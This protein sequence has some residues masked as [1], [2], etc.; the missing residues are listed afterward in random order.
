MPHLGTSGLCIRQKQKHKAQMSA[1]LFSRKQRIK[2]RTNVRNKDGMAALPITVWLPLTQR[3]KGHVHL[4]SSL[5][6]YAEI[7]TP[8]KFVHR[9]VQIYVD[10]SVFLFRLY[11]GRLG[12]VQ[13][14]LTGCGAEKHF[15]ASQGRETSFSFTCCHWQCSYNFQEP[16]NVRKYL[17]ITLDQ[18]L[19]RTAGQLWLVTVGELDWPHMEIR[20]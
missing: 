15:Q 19:W 2:I 7:V 9:Q 16:E 14:V 4:G 1:K 10:F 13:T 18:G 5:Q 11:E 12:S 6:Y 8:C 3:T 20:R 17:F